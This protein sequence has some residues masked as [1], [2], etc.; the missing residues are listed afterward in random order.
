MQADVRVAHLALDLGLGRECG[1][2]VDHHDIHRARAHQHVGDFQRL[3]TGVRLRHQQ[4][5]DLD[6]EL[7]GVGRIERVFSI[8]ERGG[9]AGALAGRDDLQRHGG[10]AGRLR[11]VDL[12]HP[13]TWQATDAECDVEPQRTG[14]N[15]VDRLVD[16]IAHA[17][18]R[19]LAELLF[20]LAEGG[21]ERLALVVIHR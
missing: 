20:D 21:S 13:A 16:A 17:H 12:D 19:A 11:A 18:D 3:L 14:G 1:H 9:T 7:F 2:R 10:L 6:P 15:H 5:V 8:D 4:I